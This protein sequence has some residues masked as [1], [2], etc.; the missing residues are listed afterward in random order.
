M[1]LMVEAE[2]ETGLTRD[3]TTTLSVFTKAKTMPITG[4]GRPT[5]SAKTFITHKTGLIVFDDIYLFTFEKIH[6]FTISP[7]Q[8]N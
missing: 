1:K 8:N 4:I 2:F 7:M 6:F 3:F 5:E